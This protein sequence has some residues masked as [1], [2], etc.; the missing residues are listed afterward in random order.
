MTANKIVVVAI[1]TFVFLI[2]CSAYS[3]V[4]KPSRDCD[5]FM[6]SNM[7]SI[8]ARCVNYFTAYGDSVKE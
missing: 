7:S 8:P 3:E 4:R 5:F 1:L 2:F 6:N